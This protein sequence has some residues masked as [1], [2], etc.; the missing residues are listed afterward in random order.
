[1]TR[2]ARPALVA[3]I[4]A[5]DLRLFVRD[6]LWMT[7][8]PLA[9]VLFV[10]LFWLLPARVDETLEVGVY[11]PILAETLAALRPA[12]GPAAAGGLDV[13]AFASAAQLAA[14]VQGGPA[15]GGHDDPA[16]APA[17]GVAFPD[18][19]ALAALQGRQLTVQL[20]LR[21]SVPAAVRGAMGSA[22]REAAYG[23]QAALRGR[24]YAASLPV[25][26][27][28]IETIVVGE[29]RAGRQTTWRDRFRPLLACIVLMMEALAIAGL[30][31]VEI[32]QRTVTAVLVT[33]VRAGDLITAKVLTG[34]LLAGV[35]ALLLLAATG[36]LGARWPVLVVLIVPAAL[37]MSAVGIIA[38]AAGKDFIA[39]L[40]YA[41][42]FVVPLMVPAFGV[43]LPGATAA[44][45]R[46]LPS[47]A[48]VQGVFAVADRGAGW[49][50]AAPYLAAT[51]AWSVVLIVV[52]T[53]VL[54]KKVVSL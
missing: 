49:T 53:A 45:V 30:V 32:Q 52:A 14:A 38:G 42:V 50:Q 5:K 35:Q 34:A 2:P 3:A 18:D 24:T 40:F 23:L 51:A 29:D 48:F 15:G 43:L 9:L 21:A 27:P 10:A 20:Y 13:V 8:T 6:R 41:M 36:S 16:P 17:I 39:T 47:Y 25:R 46:C 28:G 44:W 54:R 37:L 26:L 19:F 33:P 11:P 4:V 22:L 31:A 1:M 12:A 7:M